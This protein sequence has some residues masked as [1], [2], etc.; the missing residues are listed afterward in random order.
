M[1]RNYTTLLLL[2]L[3]FLTFSCSDDSEMPQIESEE[4]TSNETSLDETEISDMEALAES[5][6]TSSVI[7]DENWQ[8]TDYIQHLHGE[9]VVE[10]NA[11]LDPSNGVNWFYQTLD[12]KGG[13]ASITGAVEGWKEYVIWRMKDGN[14]LVGE[15]SVG[16]GPACT[17]DYSFYKGVGSQVETIETSEV[18]PVDELMEYANELQPKAIKE[19]PLDYEEDMQLVYV[20]PQKGTGMQ[21]DLVLGADEL[22]I[23]LANLSWDKEK[24]S[25]SSHETTV[26]LIAG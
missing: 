15:L 22:R 7:S 4:P 11:D 17:Y 19:Y 20:F 8:I 16:C 23:K 18:I 21:V 5:E 3:I 26:Q 24:F 13:Y 6:E 2:G 9:K 14:D 1:K 12:V 10:S 25:V